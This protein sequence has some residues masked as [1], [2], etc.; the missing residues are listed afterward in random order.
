MLVT[1]LSSELVKCRRCSSSITITR[2]DSIIPLT[3]RPTL[4]LSYY[5]P[6]VSTTMQCN[7]HAQRHNQG[8]ELAIRQSIS[9]ESPSGV[10]QMKQLQD[11]YYL[12]NDTR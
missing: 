6:A 12:G 11:T 5:R 4:D 1:Y 10:C 7:Q 2:R 9:D 3:V 8:N